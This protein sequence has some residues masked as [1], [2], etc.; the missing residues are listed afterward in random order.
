ME[1]EPQTL[2]EAILYF[3]DPK[4]C[5][6]YLV[7]RRWPNG[8]E[9]PRCGSR[10]VVFS[11]KFNRWQC[12]SHHERRQ[13]TLKTGTIFEDSPLGLDKWLAAMWMIASCKNGVSSYEIGDALGVT[14]KSAWFMLHRIREVMQGAAG[15]TKLSGD[16]EADE[17]FVGGKVTNM[18]RKSKRTIQ[19]KNDG[20]WGKTVVLGLLERDGRARAAVAPTRKHY[21]IHKNVTANVEPGSTVFSDEYD[22]YQSLPAEFT[23]EM[24]NKLEGY[25]RG[26]VHVNGMENFWSLLKRTL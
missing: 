17:T 18:H 3:A 13:F 2:Q 8:V 4:N 7:A 25:V 5:R 14:Q 24:V 1:H 10:R 16:V 22:A 23:H 11:E 26:R 12:G 21:E 9:C 15:S 20:N 6:E 19:A